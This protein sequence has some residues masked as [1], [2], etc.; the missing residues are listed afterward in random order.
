MT[1]LR[2]PAGAAL[3]VLALLGSPSFAQERGGDAQAPAAE[4]QRKDPQQQPRA[5]EGQRDPQQPPADRGEPGRG[6]QP[7]HQPG[8]APRGA[9]PGGDAPLRKLAEEEAKHRAT[10][11][12]LE[13]LRLL[14][15]EK[16][17]TERLAAL[18]ELL[19]KENDRYKAMRDKARQMM[20]DD[21]F[22][23]L[24]ERLAAGRY[25]GQGDRKP[26]Q[27]PDANRKPDAPRPDHPQ[28]QAP[29]GERP[30][31][32]PQGQAPAAD[33]PKNQPQQGGQRNGS[34]RG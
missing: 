19:K 30:K 25:R 22:R 6:A 33:R 20:G 27:A 1:T 13:R 15:E 21:N 16:G 9:G 11:A 17:Q 18:A 32:P 12:K 4:P 2:H 34:P 26:P 10:L 23:A 5:G 14:A 29:Q 8:E 31:N 7:G 28:G 3:L 24:E